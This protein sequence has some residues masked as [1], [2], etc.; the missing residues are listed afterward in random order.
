MDKTVAGLLGAMGAV[1]ASSSGQAAAP[2]TVL[3]AASYA[4]LLR[5]IPNAVETLKAL[6]ALE[7]E[8]RLQDVQYYYPPN[9]YSPNYYPPTYYAPLPYYGRFYDHHHHHHNRYY[10]RPRYHHHH[11]HGYR[12]FDRE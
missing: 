1:V 2:D 3:K 6:D 11:H 4:E 7:G 8:A 12:G 5:P 9:Y 10:Y